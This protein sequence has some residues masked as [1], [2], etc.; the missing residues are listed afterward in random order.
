MVDNTVT[1][2]VGEEMEAS[3]LLSTDIERLKKQKRVHGKNSNFEALYE[4][5]KINVQ[6]EM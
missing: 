4:T 2:E 3:L 5:F 6:R 1:G